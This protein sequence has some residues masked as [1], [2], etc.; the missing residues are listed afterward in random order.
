MEKETFDKHLKFYIHNFDFLDNIEDIKKYSVPNKDKDYYDKSFKIIKSSIKEEMQK[1]YK[2]GKDKF[3]KKVLDYR[4]KDDSID[5]S[6]KTKSLD[7]VFQYLDDNKLDYNFY[8]NLVKNNPNLKQ[9][10]DDIFIEEDVQGTVLNELKVKYS[11]L[12]TLL[13]AYREN[14]F[15]LDPNNKFLTVEETEELFKRIRSGDKSAQDEII[16]RNQGLI[17]KIAGQYCLRDNA[18]ASFEDLFQDGVEG[19]IKAIDRYDPSRKVRF[20]TYAVY[21]I[22][23]HIKRSLDNNSRIVRIPSHK[24][25]KMYKIKYKIVDII[26]EYGELPEDELIKKLEITPEE[27]DEYQFLSQ[28]SESVD[29]DQ[30]TEDKEDPVT[31][32]GKLKSEDDVEKSAIDNT[33]GEHLV[34]VLKEILTPREQNIIFKRFG[35]YGDVMSLQDIAAESHVTRERV[36]QIE[37]KALKKITK[38]YEVIDKY[39]VVNDEN[40]AQYK[41]ELETAK[42]LSLVYKKY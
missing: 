2:K 38:I 12:S 3:I 16:L 4:L 27:Y 19:I 6:V 5:N 22:R 10:L 20:T 32:L 41:K 17:K 15:K 37:H 21:W 39:D 29:K 26:K 28:K 7:L 36:R 25:D 24:L 14:Y 35:F 30:S 33:D 9:L 11:H 8:K 18:M 13:D 23:Q 1:E 31:I 42:R 34:K 40:K